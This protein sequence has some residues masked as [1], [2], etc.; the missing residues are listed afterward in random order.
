MKLSEWKWEIG[1]LAGIALF[2]LALPLEPVW[3]AYTWP[4]LWGPIASDAAGHDLAGIRPGYTP[5]STLTYSLLTIVSLLLVHRVFRRT[6][7]RIDRGFVLAAIPFVALGTI[8]RVLEDARYFDGSISFIFIS[9]I[10]YAT[11]AGLLFLSMAMGA[12]VSKVD[13]RRGTLLV[14]LYL[15]VLA[16]LALSVSAGS[17]WSSPVH[18]VFVTGSM[19]LVFLANPVRIERTTLTFFA[20]LHLLFLSFMPITKWLT[21][22]RWNGGPAAEMHPEVV[23][24]VLGITIALTVLVF[25]VWRLANTRG[26]LGVAPTAIPLFFAQF[27][28]GTAT[29]VGI[30]HYGAWEKHPL[31]RYLIE[32]TGTA[33]V[34]IPLKFAIVAF[35]VY[36]VTGPY[37][38]DLEK[39]P[40]MYHLLYLA[41]FILGFAPGMRDMLRT[42]MGV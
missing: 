11:V 35:F 24:M 29:Y 37:R 16:F 15:I 7:V 32:E 22:G 14:I 3:S 38:K 27:L 31:P 40:D 6:G 5:V 19:V 28:D 18:I 21:D 23:P 9:P 1:A 36:M 17:A 39:D 12:L 25:V 26:A 34:L 42:A 10:M 4:Y 13:R 20:G 8:L 33:A 2:L 41:V 30:D